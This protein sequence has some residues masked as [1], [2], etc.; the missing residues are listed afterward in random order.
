[1]APPSPP[2]WPYPP[3]RLETAV[4]ARRLFVLTLILALA[5]FTVRPTTGD[6]P[7]DADDDDYLASRAEQIDFLRG[8]PFH[9]PS[10]RVNAIIEMNEQE[11]LLQRSGRLS[12]ASWTPVGPAPIP[13]GQVSG[14]PTPVSGR[15]S[16][17]AVHP[18]DPNIVYV[19]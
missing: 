5:L 18:S 9:D 15:V 4:N 19:G 17:I 6:V 11:R 16:A 10:V 2:Q 13:N 1:M 7:P 12:A 14:A 8:L 3:R